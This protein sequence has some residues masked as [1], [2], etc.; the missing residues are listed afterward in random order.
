MNK[1][2]IAW[3][4]ATWNP[5]TGC[6]QISPGCDHCYAREVTLRFPHQFP[7]GFNF[8][9]HQDRLL[10]PKAIT[11]GKRIFV[12]SMSDLFH[13]KMPNSFLA[14]IL[15]VISA[16]PQ[17]TYLV[18]TKRPRPMSRRLAELG[19]TPPPNLW[20]GV[21]VET[22]E[23]AASRIEPLLSV[24]ASVHWVSAEPLLGPLDLTPWLGPD[25]I[26]W[27]VAGG[28]SGRKHRPMDPAWARDLRDQCQAS[29]VSFF[30]KQGSA[31]RPGRDA[32]LDGVFHQE[33]PTPAPQQ[34]RTPTPEKKING[35][36]EQ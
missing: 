2:A 29:G 13:P 9:I 5:T 36:D 33:F 21:S 4:E 27:V 18:L 34:Q 3:A 24:P 31:A 28:E 23:Y 12:N 35:G 6:T 1:T 17:H 26:S 11:K 8:T 25:Q 30:Y 20:L 10:Q 15:Q 7:N 19:V 22:Q 16:T 14:A 32:R